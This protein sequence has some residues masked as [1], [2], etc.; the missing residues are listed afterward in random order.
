MS[1]LAQSNGR[2]RSAAPNV[3]IV[4]Y[5][6][7][8]LFSVRQ[9]CLHA[10]LEAQITAS[11]RLIQSADAII[12]PGVGAFGD[13]M[14]ALDRLDLVAPLLDYVATGNPFVGICLGMQLMMTE[15]QEFGRHQGLGIIDGEVA[16]LAESSMESSMDSSMDSP[17]DSPMGGHK[18]KVPQVGWNRIFSLGHSNPRSPTTGSSQQWRGSLL[19]GIDDGAYM[20]FVHSFYTKPADPKVELSNTRYGDAEFCSSF[21]R[22]NV[23]GCQFHPERSGS[24]GLRI[25]QNLAASLV[26]PEMEKLDAGG[27]RDAL[28]TS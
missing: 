16:R 10:G 9:A 26:T 1:N 13:A 3:A 22:G 18:L 19:D 17:M 14:A 25:Y 27:G 8:N 4:D 12:L 5:G 28:R 7:G 20:Y 23:F 24:Q 15:S 11:Q 2:R 21:L 6:M